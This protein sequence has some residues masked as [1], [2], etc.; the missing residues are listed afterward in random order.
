MN[1][2]DSEVISRAD[3]TECHLRAPRFATF[4]FTSHIRYKEL[5]MKSRC[6][7]NGLIT[8]MIKFNLIV[9]RFQLKSNSFSMASMKS[10]LDFDANLNNLQLILGKFF[11]QASTD[12]D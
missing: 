11:I 1:Q 8:F 6:R 9:I 3:T 2:V 12:L 4:S 10:F 5:Y 7:F